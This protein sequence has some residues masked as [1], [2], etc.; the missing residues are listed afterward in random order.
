MN[1][2][3]FEQGLADHDD[4][5]FVQY[6]VNACR[7]GVDIGFEGER[8]GLVS[9]NWPSATS[10]GGAVLKSIQDDLNKHRKLG[11]FNEVPFDN[12][13]GSP[14]GAF[15][16]KH[17]P[18]KYRVIYDLSFPPGRSVNDHIPI[19][20]FS[21][22][23]MSIDEVV[24]AIQQYGRGALLSKLD[25]ESA[26]SHILVRPED[27][28]LLGSSYWCSDC[29]CRHYLVNTVLNF[30]LRSSPSLF[31]DFAYAAMLIMKAQGV[32]YVNHYL[33]D[34]VTV[35]PPCSHIC[36]K[37]LD[38]MMKVC[39]DVGFTINPSKLVQPTT[40]IEF[41]G[42]VL[43]SERLELRISE[44][45]LRNILSELA[46]WRHRKKATKREILS[47]LG[48]LIFI[49]RVVQSSR[50]FVRRIIQL[51]K[52]VKHL[53]HKVRL[54]REFQADIEWWLAFLPSWNGVA[55]FY[56]HEWITSSAMDFYSD[57]SNV[58]VAGYWQGDWFVELTDTSHTI[59]W[60]ELYAVVLAAATWAPAWS[61]RK[62]LFHCDNMAVVQVLASGSSKN[63]ELMALLRALF[64]IAASYQ[65]TFSSTYVNIKLNVG[66]DCLSRLDFYKFW[67]LVPGANWVMTTPGKVYLDV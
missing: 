19:D 15:A 11:P 12:F 20:K 3:A 26:F 24:H 30:G 52:K 31:T 64:F 25:L 6:I 59:A 46:V 10:C 8:Q 16:K 43:D 33:D 61:G 67:S 47:L 7:Y 13:V 1:P 17:S 36:Q 28:E 23:Y 41:L 55:M 62:I 29:N 45:R 27:W 48:K 38:I 21:L 54:N 63:P 53:H 56:D 51:S 2:E 60:R 66:A 18:D 40:C 5:D 57:A 50:T 39:N 14:M 49:S 65:F 34:Y 37:N 42:I 58:A 32:S 44:E 4:R 22:T 9:E 35:G